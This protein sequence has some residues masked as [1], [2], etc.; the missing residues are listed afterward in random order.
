VGLHHWQRGNFHGATV[1]LD[2]G[3]ERLRPFA[4][5]CHTVDVAKLITDATAAREKL[6]SLGPDSMNTIDVQAVAPRIAFVR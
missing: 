6:A 4:P 1:L 3:I 5:A 2:E